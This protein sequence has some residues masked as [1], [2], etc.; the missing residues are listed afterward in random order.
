ME[1]TFNTEK[2]IDS[3]QELID[4]LTDE[5]GSRFGGSMRNW[6]GIGTRPYPLPVWN[7]YLVRNTS[8]DAIGVCSYYRQEDD[9]PGR[10]WVGWIGVLK[11]FRRQG[12]AGQMFA[13]VRAEVEQLGA[14]QLWVYTGTPEAASFYRA[15]GMAPAGRFEQV[16]LEQAA[17]SGDESVFEMRLGTSP[18]S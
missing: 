1:L 4:D 9:P 16:G 17:A 3:Y 11:R 14:N 5:L 7:V 18:A 13:R 8:G 15:M 10:Y 6:C 2:Q 12:I